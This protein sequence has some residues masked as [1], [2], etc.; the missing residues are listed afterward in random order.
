MSYLVS[1][2]YWRSGPNQTVGYDFH[3]CGSP[4][5]VTMEVLWPFPSRQCWKSKND[6]LDYMVKRNK[7]DVSKPF[8]AEDF[9]SYSCEVDSVQELHSFDNLE[10]IY[11]VIEVEMGWMETDF[12]QQETRRISRYRPTLIRCAMEFAHWAN[13]ESV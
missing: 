5:S 4:R 1:P 11:L 6:T 10:M 9:T 3:M 12:S 8:T 13:R 7:R 2:K